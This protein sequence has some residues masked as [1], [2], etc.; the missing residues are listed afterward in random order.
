MSTSVKYRHPA[1]RDL[2]WSGKGRQPKWVEA[3]LANGGSIVSL[4]VEVQSRLADQQ[5]DDMLDD[6]EAA[7]ADIDLGIGDTE[8]RNQNATLEVLTERINTSLASAPAESGQAQLEI[9]LH[10][11]GMVGLTAEEFVRAGVDEMN[12]ATV[13]MCRAGVAF[14]A[15]QEA[16]KSD[17]GR[18][19]SG[20]SEST[21]DVRSRDFKGWISEA[22]LTERRVYEAIGLAKFYARL[23][24]A[25]RSKALS[26]GKSNALLL[27]SLPQEVIDQAAESGND[28]LGKAD[29]MTVAELKDEI[30]RLQRSEKNFEA[31]LEQAK[32][33]IARLAEVRQRTTDFLLRTEELREEC[34]ALQLGAEL[35]LNSLRRLFEE[36]DPQAPEGTLQVEQLWVVANTLAARSLDL[37]EFMRARVP[38]GMPERPMTKHM[39]TPDEAIRWLQDYP[40]IENRFSAEA[41][42]RE[43]KREAVRP[44]GP[45]R[46][47]GSRNKEN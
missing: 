44:R 34:M 7:E 47:T 43:A 28:L 13:K 35:H 10:E 17:S 20:V 33:K 6:A 11:F 39:L 5:I 36:T 41:A 3:Y 32:S 8:T 12:Q 27:A 37:L 22:G 19:E 46:P 23:P 45:G 18:S 42:V 24:D 2:E 31:E 9:C 4:E 38:D 26:I 1:N 29:C 16:L 15:A 25:M 30:K 21:A 40:L 14:W